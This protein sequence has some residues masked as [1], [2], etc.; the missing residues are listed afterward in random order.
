VEGR[1]VRGVVARVLLV[2]VEGHGPRDLLRRRVDLDRPRRLAHGAEQLAGDRADGPVRRER[3]PRLA[4]VAVLGDGLAAV[5]VERDDERP[6]AVGRRQRVRLPA[7]RRQAQ[8]G[9]LQL[10]LGRREHGGE[11]AEDLRVRVDRVERR[12]PRLVGGQGGPVGHGTQPSA[13]S[14]ARRVGARRSGETG[15]VKPL[16]SPIV[17][18]RLMGRL[19]LA[20]GVVAARGRGRGMLD[21]R[22]FYR[23]A[24][25][26]RTPP[27]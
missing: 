18:Y 11:L 4:P 13:A 25:P 7:A 8:R 9:V 3:D 12:A 2:V 14:C 26:G 10:R 15:V 21:P 24:R 5:Q 1:D 19:L 17:E 27:A 16:A 6:G 23:A 20:I 22:D